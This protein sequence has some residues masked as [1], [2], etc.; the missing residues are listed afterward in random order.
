M[1]MSLFPVLLH[2]EKNNEFYTEQRG[3]VHATRANRPALT[4]LTSGREAHNLIMD[5]IFM[6]RLD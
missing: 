4:T 5:R 1:T 2:T 6:A 3:E